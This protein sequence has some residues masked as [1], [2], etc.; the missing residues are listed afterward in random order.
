V[1]LL[2]YSKK[3]NIMK[4]TRKSLL[5]ISTLALAMAICIAGPAAHAA[6]MRGTLTLPVEASWNGTVL[7]AGNYE[8]SLQY[9]GAATLV[10]V[11]NTETMKGA[12]FLASA[13]SGATAVGKPGLILTREGSEMAVTTLSVGD[14]SLAFGATSPKVIAH[15]ETTAAMK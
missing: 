5:F 12:L 8:Y 2:A 1:C 6:D 7:P 3:E 11:R 10:M 4:S 9:N 13:V 15:A 14:V